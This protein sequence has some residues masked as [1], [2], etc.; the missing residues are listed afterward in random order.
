MGLHTNQRAELHAAGQALIVVRSIR[1]QNP[2]GPAR[3]NIAPGPARSLRRV[4]IKSD[5]DYL[6]KG[7]T[8]WIY[9]WKRNSFVNQKGAAVVNA[10]LFQDLDQ[11]VE[12]LNDLGVEVQFW[13]V[14]RARNVVADHLAKS[15]LNGLSAD[16]ALYVWYS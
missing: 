7:M 6:V 3:L 4:V 15:A 16:E 5:S 2:M 11:S 13:H 1:E 12:E 10:D 9:R 8:D 14:P